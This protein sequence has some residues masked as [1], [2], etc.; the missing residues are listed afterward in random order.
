MLFDE[1]VYREAQCVELMDSTSQTLF[2]VTLLMK[3]ASNVV[4]QLKKVFG[5]C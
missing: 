3:F 4:D 1:I 2:L 5:A